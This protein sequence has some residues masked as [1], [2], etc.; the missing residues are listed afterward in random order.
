M[1]MTLFLLDKAGTGT[2]D[3]QWEYKAD[4]SVPYYQG[5]GI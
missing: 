2:V 4:D 1:D 3:F 5:V